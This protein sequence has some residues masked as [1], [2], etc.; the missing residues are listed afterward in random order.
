MNAI[1]PLP[2][3]RGGGSSSS[4]CR[5]CSS[6]KV[7][8]KATGRASKQASKRVGRGVARQSGRRASKQAGA[9]L[10]RAWQAVNQT[11]FAVCSIDTP[12]CSCSVR[13]VSDRTRC[14][15]C[16]IFSLRGMQEGDRKSSSDSSFPRRGRGEVF[17]SPPCS[18]P[19][20]T[21]TSRSQSLT[22]ESKTEESHHRLVSLSLRF[23]LFRLSIYSSGRWAVVV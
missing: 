17:L 18:S 22:S 15:Y 16:L 6:D 2:L 13:S 14:V 12:R 5:H 8:S 3:R 11:R 1:L 20:C 19:G 9:Q 21:P 7:T 4:G 23:L 10:K